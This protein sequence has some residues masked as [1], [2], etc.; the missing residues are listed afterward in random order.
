M[1]VQ[2]YAKMAGQAAPELCT[3]EVFSDEIEQLSKMP[4][5]YLV[6]RM[7]GSLV[8]FASRKGRKK[9]DFNRIR[10][11]ISADGEPI[12]LTAR[13]PTLKGLLDAIAEEEFSHDW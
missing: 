6:D 9:P 8:C 7:H 1:R 5:E 11:A 4:L 12:V 3:L 2:F 10:P 13:N